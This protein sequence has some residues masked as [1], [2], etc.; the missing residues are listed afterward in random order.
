MRIPMKEEVVGGAHSLEGAGSST[1][2][3]SAMTHY[4][5]VATPSL[6]IALMAHF[7]HNPTHK[8]LLVLHLLT[9]LLSLAPLGSVLEVWTPEC[10][11]PLQ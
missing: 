3:T 8:S 6:G 4:P 10:L 7:S 5:L 2:P 11:T 1:Q 9:P